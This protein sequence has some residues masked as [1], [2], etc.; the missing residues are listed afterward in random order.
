[1]VSCNTQKSFEGNIV[2]AA[3]DKELLGKTFEEGELHIHV[4]EAYYGGEIITL[5]QFG[6][7]MK[8]CHIANLVGER[9]IGKA[10]E[11]GYVT[12][13]NIIKIQGTPHAQ[14]FRL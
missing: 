5:E 1:M 14:Y 4:S 3:C 12:D 8:N 6:E 13:A 7:K 11:L 10:K 2:L 9:V